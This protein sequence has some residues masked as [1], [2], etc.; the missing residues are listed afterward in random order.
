MV[1]SDEIL[2]NLVQVFSNITKG[3]TD[4]QTRLQKSIS[5]YSSNFE[6]NQYLL[7]IA[8]NK[9]LAI[10]IRQLSGICLKNNIIN[11]PNILKG[12]VIE[13]TLGKCFESLSEDLQIIR[14]TMSAVISSIATKFTDDIMLS[15]II[16]LG[17]CLDSPNE[18]LADVSVFTLLLILQD[19]G[20]KVFNLH[21]CG[22]VDTN[23]Y[24]SFLEKFI[25]FCRHPSYRIRVNSLKCINAILKINKELIHTSPEPFI[26]TLFT[27]FSHNDNVVKKGI[28]D[29]ML[30]L[31]DIP[32]E[33]L[34]SFKYRL[35]EYALKCLMDDDE[36]VVLQ[37]CEYF[38]ACVEKQQFS[39]DMSHE[40]FLSLVTILF[41]NM[42]Y[43]DE[44]VELFHY[45]DTVLDSHVPDKEEDLLPSSHSGF[46]KYGEK[47][48]HENGRNNEYTS[49]DEGYLDVYEWNLR[50]CSAATMDNLS[51]ICGDRLFKALI[52]LLEKCMNSS[53]WK[54]RE[55]TVLFLGAIS[56]GAERTI[57][58][59]M[60]SIVTFLFNQMQDANSLVRS[61]SCWT[62]S[63]HAKWIYQNSSNVD[64]LD[65]AI[66]VLLKL[67]L[68]D[69][70]KVQEAACS[71][72]SLFSECARNDLSKYSNPAFETL[73]KAL[74][75]YQKK[76]L[77]ML[78]DTVTTFVT[79][80]YQSLCDK[81]I[82]DRLFVL[83][84]DK[85]EK[86]S[87]QDPTFFSVWESVISVVITVNSYVEPY[88]EKMYLIA[89][90]LLEHTLTLQ[91]AYISFSSDV[92]EPDTGFFI[93]SLDLIGAL[94]VSLNNNFCKFLS[95]DAKLIKLIHKCCL[96]DA[97]VIK[98]SAY[99]LLGDLAKYCLQ[100]FSGY[101]I[102]F[103][104]PIVKLLNTPKNRAA[105][106]AILLLSQ[107]SQHMSQNFAEY[108]PMFF[109][110]FINI[111]NDFS[112]PISVIQNT[113]VLICRMCNCNSDE[114]SK[115][116]DSF[117]IN[118]C[119][120]L[121]SYH[122][123][124]EK[125]SSY[126]GLLM[127]VDKRLNNN[128]NLQLFIPLCDTLVSWD[129][130]PDNVRNDFNQIC[131][132]IKTQVSAEQWDEFIKSMPLSVGQRLNQIY[133][134]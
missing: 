122:D 128:F 47:D 104:D 80:T 120:V 68:D 30:T 130:P 44:D 46:S 97:L 66:K 3:D 19:G 124:Y 20:E 90:D 131:E 102:E 38:L 59:H 94:V 96:Q 56:Y 126:R 37:A 18:G 51:N 55:A 121:A 7:E 26:N 49:D 2:N 45:E 40:M 35:D 65:V 5:E 83:L 123:V 132:K 62:T 99:A 117:I 6:F 92:D 87:M 43:S 36:I 73:I 12:L 95:L 105:S 118:L 86:T 60:N 71:A 78:Y 85:W 100:Y 34:S 14:Q 101:I 58:P 116:L 42:R 106:N 125:S 41:K 88:A 129:N 133:T 54:I 4:T 63:R 98:Q 108:V 69:N 29:A 77:N 31:I 111:I 115:Y 25:Q 82:F 13:Q 1:L 74:N 75:K 16:H 110:I 84:I 114:A 21:L 23:F 89:F 11:S 70:K 81:A 10:N 39:E 93:V 112:M 127:A 103:F 24:N 28:C 27:L 113:T 32:K 57:E 72:L 67:I 107:L 119:K 76:N 91:E 33:K 109:P 79:V 134:S 64:Y 53:D 50:K 17:E 61:I 48:D 22:K 15:I 8:T 9:D 52:P